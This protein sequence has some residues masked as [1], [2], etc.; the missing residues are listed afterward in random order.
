M[1]NAAF[2][3]QMDGLNQLVTLAKTEF[4]LLVTKHSDKPFCTFHLTD[5]YQDYWLDRFDIQYFKDT[6]NT[7]NIEADFTSLIKCIAEALKG[8]IT[9]Q[10]TP[11]NQTHLQIRILLDGAVTLKHTFKL[12]L[13]VNAHVNEKEWR[14]CNRAFIKALFE[15]KTKELHKVEVKK[16]K[17]EEVDA[18][19]SHDKYIANVLKLDDKKKNTRK[20]DLINPN[21]RKQ[22]PLG[23]T[24][25]SS[26]DRFV[27]PE[28]KEG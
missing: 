7:I 2:T 5:G 28:K 6:L 9:M 12:T 22:G 13:N 15:A 16:E 23:I 14:T 10:I 11:D 4:I 19:E 20:R 21:R 17:K 3:E 25:V 1:D 26:P 8:D 27:T 24:F 18:R